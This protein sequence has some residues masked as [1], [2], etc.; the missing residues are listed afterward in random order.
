[1]RGDGQHRI[2]MRRVHHIHL[3]AQ[4]LPELL[5]PLHR[6]RVGA[7]RRRHDGPASVEQA[8]EA[9][10]GAGKFRA[11][12][13]MGGNEIHTGRHMGAHIADHRALDRAHVRQDGA[14]FQMRCDLL[15]HRSAGPDR[16]AQQHQIGIGHRA[17]GIGS[18]RIA[19]TQCG[20]TAAHIGIGVEARDL[21]RQLATP[22]RMG[23]GRADQP[24]PDD[25]DLAEP[26]PRIFH[27]TPP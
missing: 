15:R 4:A 10:L 17:S 12:D 1:M 8:G 7:R 9:R 20:G 2:V 19:K 16:H 3:A 21:A 23:D 14:R 24:Q 18:D 22:R 26:C 5:Q 6:R 25:G 13:G 27:I 11:R